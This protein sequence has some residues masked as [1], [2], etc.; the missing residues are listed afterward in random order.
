M[1]GTERLQTLDQ[2][3]RFDIPKLLQAED[4]HSPVGILIAEDE[5]SALASAHEQWKWHNDQ[6]KREITDHSQERGKARLSFREWLGELEL[7][8]HQL[9]IILVGELLAADGPELLPR[10]EPP[11]DASSVDYE[12]LFDLLTDRLAMH[13]A[14]N[15]I[16]DMLNDDSGKGA[17]LDDVQAF[18]RFVFVKQ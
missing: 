8:S 17:E 1:T 18:W 10:D 7:L 5:N 9:Q 16:S 15:G 2:R 13:Q 4:E 6:V 12:A 14:L 3:W 11:A